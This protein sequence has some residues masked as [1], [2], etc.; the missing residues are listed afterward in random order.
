M[1]C[2]V[3]VSGNKFCIGV[4]NIEQVEKAGSKYPKFGKAG[5]TDYIFTCKRCGSQTEPIHFDLDIK[6]RLVSHLTRYCNPSTDTS[7][8]EEEEKIL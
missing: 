8:E 7:E 4:I 2:S 5:K 1:T 3:I 6:Y